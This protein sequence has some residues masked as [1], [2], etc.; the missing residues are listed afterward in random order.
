[1]LIGRETYRNEM[2]YWCTCSK[3]FFHT[4][5]TSQAWVADR[6]H[7]KKA[8]TALPPTVESQTCVYPGVNSDTPDRMRNRGVDGGIARE[9]HQIGRWPEEVDCFL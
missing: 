4:S 8:E 6:R 7:D 9:A 3:P 1:M 5:V 2:P